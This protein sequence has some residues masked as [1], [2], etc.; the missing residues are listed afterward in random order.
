MSSRNSDLYFDQYWLI[1][2]IIQPPD[3]YKP[4]LFHELQ[5]MVGA[6]MA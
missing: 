3:L 5:Q 4:S 2:D 1:E 6:L